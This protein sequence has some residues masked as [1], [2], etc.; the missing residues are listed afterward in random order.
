MSTADWDGGAQE[1]NIKVP[2]SKAASRLWAWHDP[3]ADPATKGAHKFPHHMVDSSGAVGAGNV[4]ACQSIISVLNGGMGGASIPDAD[5]KGVYAHAA[6]HLKDA[7]VDAPEL[8]SRDDG[9]FEQRKSYRDSLRGERHTRGCAL[10]WELRDVPNG[11]GGSDLLF[12]GYACVTCRDLD[13]DSAAYEMEDMFGTFT[14]SVVRGAF[15]KTLSQSA[16][17][18]FLLNHDGITLARTKPGTLKLSE[19]DKGLHTEARLDPTNPVVQQIRSGVERGDLD[20]MSF[21]FRPTRQEWNEEYTRR[22]LTEVNIHQGDV[23]V[24]NYGANPHTAGLVAVRSA[25]QAGADRLAR[26][27]AALYEL[28]EGKTFSADSMSQLSNV[29]ALVSH[30]DDDV[31]QAQILLAQLMGVPNPDNDDQWQSLED[32]GSQQ[33]SAPGPSSF[34]L[35]RAL[36]RS[37]ELERKHRRKSA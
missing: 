19:D 4:K 22:W 2:V 31:D 5:R 30:A 15:K 12:V 18:A 7:G 34:E 29:L 1:K 20:E 13:D 33:N 28:R 23:S 24:V 3:D 8:K 14:E 37:R 9:H 6:A 25:E 21:A 27:L 32:G 36:Q 35:A 16:D 11:M 17:V 10:D 26:Q